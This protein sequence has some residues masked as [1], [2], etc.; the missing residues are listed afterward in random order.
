VTIVLSN[1][2]IVHCVLTSVFCLLEHRD[3]PSQVVLDKL[4]AAS[5]NLLVCIDKL[6]SSFLFD[7]IG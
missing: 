7:D 6:S 4:A 5:S 2:S 3:R 1:C